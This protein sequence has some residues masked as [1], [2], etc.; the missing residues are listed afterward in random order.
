MTQPIYVYASDVSDDFTDCKDCLFR[1][2]ENFEN[3]GKDPKGNSLKEELL[4]E[5]KFMLWFA[6]GAYEKL[7]SVNECSS[8]L[9]YEK[10]S[11][12]FQ[13][14]SLISLDSNMFW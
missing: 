13:N 1:V 2:P 11:I 3:E 4:L 6:P 12:L 8:F 5:A 9:F 10:S 7:S 14:D